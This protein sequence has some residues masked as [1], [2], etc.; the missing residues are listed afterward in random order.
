MA[1]NPEPAGA[2]GGVIV[3]IESPIATLHRLQKLEK[4]QNLLLNIGVRKSALAELLD[5]A[6]QEDPRNEGNPLPR[7]MAVLEACQKNKRC[8]SPIGWVSQAINEHW[9]LDALPGQ[10]QQRKAGAA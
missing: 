6:E 8:R 9:D 5:H 1:Q 7:V 2:G 3:E 10:S 4:A